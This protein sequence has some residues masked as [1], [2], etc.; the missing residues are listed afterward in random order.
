MAYSISVK[1]ENLL[2]VDKENTIYLITDKVVSVEHW[3]KVREIE[4]TDEYEK[5][6]AL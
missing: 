3:I 1:K 5:L 4:K 2:I 6:Y